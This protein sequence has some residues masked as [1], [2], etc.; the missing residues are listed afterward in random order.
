MV[1]CSF[2]ILCK[3]FTV[4]ILQKSAVCVLVTLFM[5]MLRRDIFITSITPTTSAIR[6]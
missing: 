3:Y 1:L 2:S 6:C 4:Q 5:G